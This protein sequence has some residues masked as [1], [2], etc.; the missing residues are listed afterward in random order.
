MTQP[1]AFS[2][3]APGTT[4]I[5]IALVSAAVLMQEIVLTRIFSFS[6]WYHL[7]YLTISTALLGFGAAGSML[8][9]IGWLG[10]VPS[11]TLAASSATVAGIALLASA[12]LIAPRPLDPLQLVNEPV[13]FSTGLLLYYLLVA[14]PFMFAGLAVVA[15]LRAYPNEVNRLYGADLCGAGLGCIGAVLGLQQLSAEAALVMCSVLFMAGG[16]FYAGRS[17]LAMGI[18]VLTVIVIA[19]SPAYTRSLK[20]VP[21]PSKIMGTA[22]Q[23]P[24]TKVIYTAWSPINRVDLYTNKEM[25]FT[26]WAGIGRSNKYTGEVPEGIS[27]Q[28]DAHNGSAIYNMHKP[29]AFGFLDQHMLKLPYLLKKSPDVLVIGVGGGIDLVNAFRNEAKHVTAVELQPL[30]LRLLTQDAGIRDWTDNF[31]NRSDLTLV[32]GEGRHF[33]RAQQHGYDLIQQTATDTFSAQST[34]AYVLAESYLYTV[35]AMQDYLNRLNEDGVLTVVIGELYYEGKMPL[36]P[37]I[38]RLSL[39]ARRAL[40]LDGDADP[41]AH[42]MVVSQLATTHLGSWISPEKGS[43][44]ESGAAHIV[45]SLMVKKSAFTP[46]E[47]RQV[48]EFADGNGFRILAAPGRQNDLELEKLLQAT[49]ETRDEIIAGQSFKLLPVTDNRPFFFHVL[50]WSSVLTGE[51]TI[52]NFPGSTTGQLILIIMLVQALLLGAVLILLPLAGK[53]RRGVITGKA[54]IGSVVYFSTLGIGFM[55]IEISFVQKYILLLGYPT[56]SLSV[57][58]FS[59]LMFAGFGAYFS[60]R[61]WNRMQRFFVVLLG[62]TVTFVIAEIALLPVIRDAFLASPLPVRILVTACL[63][64]PLGT[65]LGMYFP[66]GIAVL[67]RYSPDLIPWAWAVNGVASVVS[68]V[69]AVILGMTIG[70]SGVAAL[71]AL[72]YLVGTSVFLATTVKQAYS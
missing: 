14:L 65:C 28:Y 44:H 58:I 25:R 51:R 38:S 30:T 60:T 70:F 52:W 2:A 33:V 23:Q 62:F 20:F 3:K 68:L 64:L 10:R 11:R 6:I 37:L 17:R 39:A 40:E 12:M 9:G 18:A 27:L 56:Y 59:L 4:Y 49:P 29:N 26:Y 69:L 47:V 31:F 66:S 57:T 22:M 7:A 19:L 42:I 34:G 24:D 13:S 61:F 53:I 48:T 15:P 21:S 8:S 55:L 1:T 54:A 50:P 16:I 36:P 41:S 45:H 35:E 43:E 72:I 5:A 67:Q 32:A 46:D 63:Q 71:A